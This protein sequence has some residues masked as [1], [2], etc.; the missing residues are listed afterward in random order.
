MHQ[1][2]QNINFGD[3]KDI[4]YYPTSKYFGI[5]PKNSSFQYVEGFDFFIASIEQQIDKII[6]DSIKTQIEKEPQNLQNIFKTLF[7]KLPIF[8]YSYHESCPYNI[9]VTFLSYCDYTQGVGR[10]VP[11]MLSRWLIPGKLLS[12]EAERSLAF[13]F[14]SFPQK[15]LFFCQYYLDIKTDKELSIALKNIDKTIHELKINILAVYYARYIISLKKLT[16]EQQTTMIESYIS[17]LLDNKVKDFN[18]H[19]Q[20]Q[21][22]LLKLSAEQKYHQVKENI[23]S[24]MNS[25]PKNF[26]HDVFYEI[27]HFT[28]LFRDKFTVNRDPRH[29]S[30]VIAFQYLFKKTI[31]QSIKKAPNERHLSLKIL[32]T[33]IKSDDKERTVIGILIAMNFVKDTERFDK[34]H[35]LEAVKTYIPDIHYVKESYILERSEEKVR[36]IY[37][38]IEKKRWR[39]FQL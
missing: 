12:I 22:F 36:S 2:T 21:Q 10:Y 33:R 23:S 39:Q 37:L 6:P 19:D 3:L 26:D 31:L 25:R 30:R 13:L 18:A 1:K 35:V 14:K 8:Q 17:S 20:M 9:A 11:D 29:I 24:L 7:T 5:T 4:T 34:R 38:E 15:P 16:L 32:K 28:V 27:R